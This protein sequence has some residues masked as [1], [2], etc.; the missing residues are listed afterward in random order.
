MAAVG[1]LLNVGI[2]ADSSL[3]EESMRRKWAKIQR[4]PDSMKARR[5]EKSWPKA[6]ANIG[7]VAKTGQ[8]PSYRY[9]VTNTGWD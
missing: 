6:T 5:A 1:S 8:F 7:A 4:A 3:N 9:T 2:L